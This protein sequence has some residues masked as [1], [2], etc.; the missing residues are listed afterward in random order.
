MTESSGDGVSGECLR[1]GS[2]GATIEGIHPLAKDRP[3]EIQGLPSYRH[4]CLWSLEYSKEKE[5]CTILHLVRN[6]DANSFL[7]LRIVQK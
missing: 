6:V 4:A 7:E 5:L 3:T 1:C 2:G